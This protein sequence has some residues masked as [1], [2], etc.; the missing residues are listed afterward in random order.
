MSV[1]Y[2]ALLLCQQETE[3]QVAEAK[4]APEQSTE[5]SISAAVY[6]VEEALAK[7]G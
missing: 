2:A 4:G 1:N 7:K 3:R 6:I 5:V